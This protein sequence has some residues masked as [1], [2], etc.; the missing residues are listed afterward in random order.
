MPAADPT[1]T[2]PRIAA[3]TDECGEHLV[4]DRTFWRYYFAGQALAGHRG[5]ERGC[6][7][8]SSDLARICASDADALLA[9]LEKEKDRG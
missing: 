1:P 5:N 7:E 6:V 3:L 4:P 2:L 8:G 9:E